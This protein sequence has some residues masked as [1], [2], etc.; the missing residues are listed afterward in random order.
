MK[1]ATLARE[2]SGY[3]GAALVSLGVG[4]IYLP[5]GVI[6]AGVMLITGAV[7]SAIKG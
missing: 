1:R 7:L 4:L 6:M 3:V 5:A 2:A